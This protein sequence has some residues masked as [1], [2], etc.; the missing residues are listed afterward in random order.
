VLG[1]IPAAPPA[2]RGGSSQI[3]SANNTGTELPEFVR[4]LAA[5]LARLGDSSE[6]FP[7]NNAG[8]ELPELGQKLAAPPE[9]LGD[10][11]DF[12]LA[13]NTGAVFPLVREGSLASIAP[14]LLPL[15]VLPASLGSS[16]WSGTSLGF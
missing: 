15:K 12:F 7:A 4:K 2:H 8:T 6:F 16:L 10:L 3:L 13:N 11:L 9:R 14:P 1:Q 5:P